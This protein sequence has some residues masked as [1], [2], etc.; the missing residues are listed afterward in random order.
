MIKLRTAVLSLLT[1]KSYSSF[2]KGYSEFFTILIVISH[3][4]FTHERNVPCLKFLNFLLNK[5]QR[6]IGQ[7]LTLHHLTVKLLPNLKFANHLH[8]ISWWIVFSRFDYT[9]ATLKVNPQLTKSNI[10]WIVF[11][12]TLRRD[13]TQLTISFC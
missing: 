10:L 6:M 1:R 13:W 11:T 12:Q 4:C 8:A 7:F 9:G 5:C 2:T 3:N